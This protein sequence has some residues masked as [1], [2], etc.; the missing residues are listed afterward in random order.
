MVSHTFHPWAGCGKLKWE[1]PSL[2][3]NFLIARI[4]KARN[5]IRKPRNTLKTRKHILS[6]NVMGSLKIH[7]KFR[8]ATM[9]KLLQSTPRRR[10]FLLQM[11]R[12][13]DHEIEKD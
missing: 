1:T 4:L 7:Y 10:D 8:I 3:Q 2:F 5:K 6:Q 11:G 13:I 9:E 12:E